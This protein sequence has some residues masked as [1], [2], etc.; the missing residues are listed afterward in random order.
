MA[1]ILAT[2]STQ[3]ASS[4][5]TLAAGE[6]KTL[7]LIGI[8]GNALALVQKQN[9]AS[10]WDDIGDLSTTSARMKVLSAVGTFRVYRSAGTFGVDAD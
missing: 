10:G 5:F 9:S 8:S 7:T 1:N 6:S 3:T 2:G 4:E